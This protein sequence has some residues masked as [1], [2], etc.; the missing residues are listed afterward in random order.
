MGDLDTWRI[1]LPLANE[2]SA[3]RWPRGWKWAAAAVLLVS[4]FLAGRA[5]SR[6]SS[7]PSAAIQTEID[8]QVQAVRAELAG[9]FGAIAQSNQVEVARLFGDLTAT[10][11]EGRAADGQNVLAALKEMDARWLS[12][13]AS[14]RRELET[15][16]ILTETG[17]KDAH[18]QLVQ[19][20]DFN[21]TPK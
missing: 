11:D 5:N 6:T 7:A 14:F 16:A 18:Q 13:Y 19:M 8:R 9:H 12:V 21:E 2:K 20:T 3:P 15:V 1:A 17:L 10:I 4:A